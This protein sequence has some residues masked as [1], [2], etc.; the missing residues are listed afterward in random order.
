MTELEFALANALRDL[1]G[2]HRHDERGTCL[3]CGRDN[4]GYE[5]EPCSD[6]CPDE[7]ARAAL[8]K[9]NDANKEKND[10][11]HLQV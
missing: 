9:F 5:N 6:D 2:E 10:V 8:K 1:L 4:S 11:S 3:H 7:V